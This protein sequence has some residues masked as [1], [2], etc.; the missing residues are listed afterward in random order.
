M[1]PAYRK[2]PV[3]SKDTDSDVPIRAGDQKHNDSLQTGYKQWLDYRCKLPL[4]IHQ[5]RAL[6]NMGIA[7]GSIT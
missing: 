1:T 7:V 5:S 4:H 3:W 2:L 6:G